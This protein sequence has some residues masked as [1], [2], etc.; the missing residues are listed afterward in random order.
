M[1]Q[2]VFHFVVVLVASF[3]ICYAVSFILAF[4]ILALIERVMYGKRK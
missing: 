1:L 3:T 4:L 2:A